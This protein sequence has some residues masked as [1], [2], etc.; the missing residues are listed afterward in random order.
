[1]R[2]LLVAA[3]LLITSVQ[4]DRDDDTPEPAG[5]VAPPPRLSEAIGSIRFGWLPSARDLGLAAHSAAQ[6]SYGQEAAE[7]PLCGGRRLSSLGA[8]A[9][10]RAEF[11]QG[12]ASPR[13]VVVLAEFVARGQ[14]RRAEAVLT[15]SMAA[16]PDLAGL[17]RETGVVQVG[18][19]IAVVSAEY[20]D[21][22][23]A[24]HLPRVLRQ[25]SEDFARPGRAGRGPARAS[26]P[27]P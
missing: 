21:G 9:A 18:K 11:G 7:V 19:L 16:C 15:P 1:M 22:R 2:G 17:S 3:L 25:L 10:L 26:E 6:T 23:G 24:G 20:A 4:C 14:A 8:V 5:E 12:T 27:G 13:A